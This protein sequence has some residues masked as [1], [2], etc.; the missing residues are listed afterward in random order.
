VLN[1]VAAVNYGMER[2]KTLRL[3]IRLLREIH[4]ELLHNVRGQE[5]TRE[6]PN[7]AKLDWP[8]WLSNIERG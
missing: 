1:Y 2:L 8:G 7:D 5:K 4:N 3:S 6:R